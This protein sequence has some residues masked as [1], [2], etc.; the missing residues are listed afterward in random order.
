MS[1]EN[2]SGQTPYTFFQMYSYQQTG[3]N[4]VGFRLNAGQGATHNMQLITRP[5]SK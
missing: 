4:S 2:A 3:L 5:Y 1:V